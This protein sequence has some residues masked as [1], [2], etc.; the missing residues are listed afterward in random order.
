M[1]PSGPNMAT[2]MQMIMIATHLSIIFLLACFASFV[3]S[4]D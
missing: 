4:V 2:V 1:Q 3:A